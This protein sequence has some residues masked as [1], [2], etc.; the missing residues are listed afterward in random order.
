MHLQGSLSGV[1]IGWLGDLGGHLATEPGILEICERALQRMEGDGAVV[2]PTLLNV[3]LDALWT[4]WLHNRHAYNAAKYGALLKREATAAQIK[5]E[6]RWEAETGVSLTALICS[7][8]R[9]PEPP[10]TNRSFRCSSTPV[11]T[12]TYLRCPPLRCGL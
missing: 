6:V 9:P 10:S 7:V 5:E 3:D 1:R 8:L 4:S 2:V 12:S 11:A